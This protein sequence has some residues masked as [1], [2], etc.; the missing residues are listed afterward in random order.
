M[1]TRDVPVHIGS[2]QAREVDLVG[3]FR[4]AGCYPLALGVL[5]RARAVGTRRGRTLGNDVVL[6]LCLA[7]GGPQG[8][9]HSDE[10][11][12]ATGS[13]RAFCVG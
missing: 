4:Y 8:D 10:D 12:P 2:L 1:G 6:G 3:C 13:R 9:G 11:Q 7:V 5:E